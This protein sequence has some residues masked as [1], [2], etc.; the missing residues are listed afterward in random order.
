MV[1]T[2]GRGDRAYE[3]PL[4]HDAHGDSD[5]IRWGFSYI[6]LLCSTPG[7]KKENN[8]MMTCHELHNEDIAL[9]HIYDRILAGDMDP[10]LS[11][12]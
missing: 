1:S 8:E 7:T 9:H 2:V 6:D 4:Y 11:P 3:Y 5:R 12:F 10:Y